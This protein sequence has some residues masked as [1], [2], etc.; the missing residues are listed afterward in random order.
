[1]PRM[2]LTQICNNTLIIFSCTPPERSQDCLKK[3][4]PEQPD[5]EAE[6]RNEDETDEDDDVTDEDGGDDTKNLFWPRG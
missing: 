1:M 2:I 6:D 3:K 5:I 4:S